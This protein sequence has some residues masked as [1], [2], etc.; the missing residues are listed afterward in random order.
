ML[1]NLKRAGH[2]ADELREELF[3]ADAQ[4]KWKNVQ[5][6]QDESNELARF[7]LAIEDRE[8]YP[9]VCNEIF[10]FIRSTKGDGVVDDRFLERYYLIK[11]V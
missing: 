10:K 3:E 11:H 4:Y 8:Q 1:V 6:W 7:V 5:T 2:F 9:D